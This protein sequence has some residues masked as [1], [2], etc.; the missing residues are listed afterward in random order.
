MKLR[1]TKKTVPFLGHPVKLYT[2]PELCR[3]P[4]SVV[5]SE[6][7]CVGNQGKTW[8]SDINFSTLYIK[9]YHS[10]FRSRVTGV[11]GSVRLRPRY[12]LGFASPPNV[13]A[14]CTRCPRRI[15][16]IDINGFAARRTDT[17]VVRCLIAVTATTT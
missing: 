17:P 9:K 7:A 6:S 10:Q 11:L 2:A 15:V 1:R 14:A 3:L 16:K 5:F 4:P 13:G 12:R 8:D